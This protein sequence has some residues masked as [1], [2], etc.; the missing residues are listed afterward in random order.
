M[1]KY[2]KAKLIKFLKLNKSYITESIIKMHIS[3]FNNII[4]EKKVPSK[5][6]NVYIKCDIMLTPFI[7]IVEGIP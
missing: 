1:S 7:S 4:F 6:K 3:I 2:T 5:Y